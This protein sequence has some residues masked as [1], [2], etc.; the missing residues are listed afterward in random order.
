MPAEVTTDT[1]SLLTGKEHVTPF[2]KRYFGQEMM[3]KYEPLQD[4]LQKFLDSN[5]KDNEAWEEFQYHY[6]LYENYQVFSKWDGKRYDIVLYG[7]SG[8]TGYLM[9]EYL[10][11]VS[12]KIGK[13]DFTVAFAGRTASKVADMR[14]KEFAGTQWTDIPV[15]RASFDD[16]ISM[17]DLARSARVIINV[18]GPYMLT[19]GEIMIDACI[20][21]GTHYC[22]ISGE[23]PWTLRVLE[24]HQHALKHGVCVIPSAASAGG[25]PDMAV[26]MC[27]KKMREDFGGDEL[28]HAECYA[29]GG[30]TPA[31]ASGGTLKTRAAM[32]G[33]GD[34]VRAAMGNPFSLGGF[35]P[36]RDRNG[37]KEVTVEYGT[38]KVSV[39][40]RNEE[41]DANMAR[42]TE[43][44]RLGVWRG[45][46][47]YQ[48]FD[49]RIV[50]RSNAL[51]ADLTKEPYGRQ[52]RFMEYALL[53]PEAVAAMSSAGIKVSANVANEAEALKAA[54]KFYAEGEGPPLEELEDAWTSFAVWVESEGGRELKCS[55]LGRDGY[56]ETARVA[57][58]MA[59][60]LCFDRD[61]LPV[62]GGVLSPTVAGGTCVIKRIIDSGNN[63]RMGDW[64]RWS[65]LKPPP[66]P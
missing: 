53:P 37:I 4:S 8:Y 52:L 62:Q 35:I 2:A 23:I 11:R 36:A 50:R 45:P 38:G 32:A 59:M 20:H 40:V 19:E 17:A 10:K 56:F 34:D 21:M 15:L 33:A 27:A 64:F 44:K 66:F 28:R 26:F 12:Y 9:M 22:D 14:D 51:L 58:E 60:T 39:N 63:F 42:I 3:E 31:T 25:Y 47:V 65:E 57:I 16:V 54:G 6:R 43:N 29:C 18:A 61:K 30:G 1:Y 13:E 7:V 49:T 46:F 41:K 48:Y 5:G 24:L 55:F